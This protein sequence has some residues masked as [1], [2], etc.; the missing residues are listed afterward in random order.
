MRI[1]VLIVLFFA[2]FGCGGDD[3]SPANNTPGNNTPGNNTPGNNTPGNNPDVGTPLSGDTLCEQLSSCCEQSGEA[4][5][6]EGNEGI[7]KTHLKARLGA[8]VCGPRASGSM[9]VAILDGGVET[10][11]EC[12]PPQENYDFFYEFNDIENNNYLTLACEGAGVIVSL[13]YW[14]G[15]T[16]PSLLR[17]ERGFASLF[18]TDGEVTADIVWESG[19]ADVAGTYSVVWDGPVSVEVTLAIQNVPTFP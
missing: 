6:P 17:L 18:S 9:T 19:S 3:E 16:K 13:G 14:Q 12:G 11:L 15:D 5:C 10:S 2:S 8:G 1:P 4:S 7:C